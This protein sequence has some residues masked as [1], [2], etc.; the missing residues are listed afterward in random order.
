MNSKMYLFKHPK[1]FEETDDF[2]F[3]N[4]FLCLKKKQQH[5]FKSYIISSLVFYC[6]SYIDIFFLKKKLRKQLQ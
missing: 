3:S 5:V 4:I 1:D 6:L 2:F